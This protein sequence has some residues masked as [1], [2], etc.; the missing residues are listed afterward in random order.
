MGKFGWTDTLKM[1]N[2][3][4]TK[5]KDNAIES[6]TETKCMLNGIQKQ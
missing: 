6:S 4:G 3:V 1:L 5:K 2:E